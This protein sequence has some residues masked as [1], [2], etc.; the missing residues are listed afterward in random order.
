MA[1]ILDSADHM[2]LG[3]NYSFLPMWHNNSYER[4]MNATVR[5]YNYLEL[6]F[7]T[8]SHISSKLLFT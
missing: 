5:T 3:N 2:V 1:N 6:P 4:L 8:H 7:K